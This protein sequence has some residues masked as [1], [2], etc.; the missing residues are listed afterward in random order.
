MLISVPAWDPRSLRV[1]PTRLQSETS[2]NVLLIEP[3]ASQVVCE[4][5]EIHHRGIS[6]YTKK[7]GSNSVMYSFDFVLGLNRKLHIPS[8]SNPSA[9][10]KHK[11]ASLISPLLN[12][13]PLDP[14]SVASGLHFHHPPPQL[15]PAP[16][17]P[18]LAAGMRLRFA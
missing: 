4:Q 11:C 5:K 10:P 7:I 13:S 18:P 12:C 14:P 1:T 3:K 16:N 17:P 15:C 6:G 8:T 9:S 2:N